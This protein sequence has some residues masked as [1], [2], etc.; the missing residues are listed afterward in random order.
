M[1]RYIKIFLLLVPLPIFVFIEFFHPI[2][3]AA[4]DLGYYLKIGEVIFATKTVPAINLFSYTY[5]NSPFIN[6]NWLSE[7]IFYLISTISGFTDLMVISTIIFVIAV[8]IPV[9]YVLKYKKGNSIT[10]LYISF[11]LLVEI[12]VVRLNVKP[13]IFSLLFTSLFVA[14][15][16]AYKRNH[17]KWIYL[18]PLLELVWV[19]MHVFFIVGIFLVFIFVLDSLFFWKFSKEPANNEVLLNS[20]KT[21]LI[22]FFFTILASFF[23]PFGINGALYPITIQQILNTNLA[24]NQSVFTLQ[25]IGFAPFSILLFEISA[26]FLFISLFIN[27]KKASLA[28]WFIAIG[29]FILAETHSRGLG[30]YVCAVFIPLYLNVEMI[31]EK[32]QRT[33]SISSKKILYTL[34]WI[35]IIFLYIFELNY[36]VHTYGFG[37]GKMSKYENGVNFFLKEHLHGPIFNNFSVGSYL[38]YRLYPQEKVFIDTRPEAYPQSFSQNGYFSIQADPKIFQKEDSIYHFNVIVYDYIEDSPVT[39]TFTKNI[40]QDKNWQLI[41]LDDT[42][43]ILVK[44]NALNNQV[45]TNFGMSENTFHI[46]QSDRKN[47]HLLLNIGSFLDTVGWRKQEVLVLQ[48]ALRIDPQSCL[49]LVLISDTFHTIGDNDMANLYYGKFQQFCK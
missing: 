40:M 38:E 30:L 33:M 20:V 29:F 48:E 16:Y 41:Y 7:V 14:I 27:R 49:A 2:S 26:V 42:I 28:D 25:S 9:V 11:L 3:S 31:F 12:L 17:T 47:L 1:L 18:L 6:P 15:L 46:S 4:V 37:A 23:N 39:N 35:C 8:M 19:N 36:V 10:S 24:E 5:P 44:K 43:M 32:V 21:L 13:E 45:I 22:I 34:L